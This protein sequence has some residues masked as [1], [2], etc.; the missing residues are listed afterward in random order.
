MPLSTVAAL[1]TAVAVAAST[2][3]AAPGAAAPPEVRWTCAGTAITGK[4]LATRFEAGAVTVTWEGR[5]TR[6]RAVDS[7]V[8]ARYLAPTGEGETGPS[9]LRTF[10]D[11]D[12]AVFERSGIAIGCR[13]ER[14]SP[15]LPMPEPAGPTPLDL[16][17]ALVDGRPV[18]LSQLVS[19]VG[20]I[21]RDP[22]VWEQAVGPVGVTHGEGTIESVDVRFSIDHYHFDPREQDDPLLAS[23]DATFRG[24]G[25]VGAGADGVADLLRSRYGEGLALLHQAGWP[26]RFGPFYLTR[27]PAG[28]FRLSFFR[29]EPG[30][31]V[32]PR[33][34]AGSRD[35]MARI[36][37]FLRGGVTLASLEAAFGAL[38]PDSWGESLEGETRHWRISARPAAEPFDR[39]FLVPRG[40]PIPAGALIPALGITA[41][42]VVSHDVHLSSR[43]LEDREKGRPKVGDYEIEMAIDFGD[44]V[45][46]ELPPDP[47]RYQPPAWSSTTFAITGIA[48]RRAGHP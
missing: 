7:E 10:A 37:R 42:I 39:V 30:W 22:S 43:N 11:G 48:V 4:P 20:P 47:S 19:L 18:V 33:S 24:G 17:T 9:R 35:E 8:G 28:R 3:V 6:L 31:A 40:E 5:A 26:T 29:D 32:P 41:P 23:W 34:E 38:G 16:A 13:A 45:L 12:R 25:G 1:F 14:R 15:N 21:P 2:A 44:L 27:L 46:L 36:E